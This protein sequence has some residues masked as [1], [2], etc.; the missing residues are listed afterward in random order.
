MAREY[1]WSATSEASSTNF[2]DI[3]RNSGDITIKEDITV[4]PSCCGDVDGYAYEFILKKFP[5]NEYGCN[6]TPDIKKS[7]TVESC[8]KDYLVT[9]FKDNSQSG[10]E[11]KVAN[12]TD[13]FTVKGVDDGDFEAVRYSG[14][15][16][17][18]TRS[19]MKFSTTKYTDCGFPKIKINPYCACSGD[20]NDGNVKYEANTPYDKMHKIYYVPSSSTITSESFSNL[21]ELTEVYFPSSGDSIQGNPY[22]CVP[23][24]TIGSGAFSGCNNLSAVT[25]SKVETIEQEAFKNCGKLKNIDW[26]NWCDCDSAMKTISGSAFE[27]CS[28][29]TELVFPASLREIGVNAF[30]NCSNLTSV[31][32]TS[33]NTSA[34]ANAF[35]NCTKLKTVY[36]S[37][38]TTPPAWAIGGFTA[39]FSDFNPRPQAGYEIILP[40]GTKEGILEEWRSNVF[41]N[42]YTGDIPE[43]CPEF[44]N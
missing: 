8:A 1:G 15:C 44:K 33:E 11:F 35:S 39:A 36:F 29:L 12:N 10:G 31:T 2:A 23:T 40:M 7:L 25:F 41:P 13:I 21:P 18:A 38:S 4:L 34:S 20:C 24:Q 9:W 26:A 5:N 42:T 14:D 28:G 30:T 19:P 43:R 32:F 27:N 37:F 16:K 22:D 3:H 17:F 6:N